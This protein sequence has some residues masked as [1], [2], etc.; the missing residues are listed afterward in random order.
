MGAELFHSVLRTRLMKRGAQCAPR[1]R[2]SLQA[3][4]NVAR[5]NVLYQDIQIDQT[6]GESHLRSW[7]WLRFQRN[8]KPLWHSIF[9][10]FTVFIGACSWTVSCA[11]LIKC[12][13]FILHNKIDFNIILL[14]IIKLSNFFLNCLFSDLLFVCIMWDTWHCIF[15]IIYVFTNHSVWNIFQFWSFTDNFQFPKQWII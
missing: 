13:P 10:I 6:A 1:S 12:Q 9:G 15:I 3:L 11:K 8:Y 7:Q 4:Q 5:V 14:S 2:H